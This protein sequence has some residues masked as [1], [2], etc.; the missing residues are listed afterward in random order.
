MFLTLRTGS[1]LGRSH[2]PSQEQPS[3]ALTI[4]CLPVEASLVQRGKGGPGH[5]CSLAGACRPGGK[6]RALTEVKGGESY[7]WGGFQIKGFKT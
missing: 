4:P 7:F 6:P 1:G 5:T 3:V 2:P